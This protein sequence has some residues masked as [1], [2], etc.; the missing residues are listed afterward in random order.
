MNTT[1]R[2]IPAWAALFTTVLWAAV[3]AVGHMGHGFE[4]VLIAN[5][6]CFQMLGCN[7]GFFGYDGLTH[8]LSGI[9]AVFLMLWLSEK[10]PR[11]NVFPD[12]RL[13]KALAIVAF[14]ALISFLWEFLEYAADFFQLYVYHIPAD[15]LWQSSNPDTMGDIGLSLG[16]ATLAI[17]TSAVFMARKR[18]MNS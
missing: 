10:Y 3:Y 15:L 17:L 18:F 5:D 14:M 8:F 9:M 2:P 6:W 4:E 11:L 13:K 16:G 1:V 12:G 7:V